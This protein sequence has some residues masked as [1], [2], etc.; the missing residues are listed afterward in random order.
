MN[1]NDSEEIM[2]IY[3]NLRE[4]YPHGHEKFIKITLNEM[5][6][7]SDKNFDYASGGHSLGNFYRVSS[8]LSLYPGLKLSQPI[9]VCIVYALKQIDAVL[10]SLSRGEEGKVEGN[11]KRLEY[12]SVYIKIAQIIND[13]K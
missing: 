7:H 8:I 1:I 4:M 10:W 5:K 3:N 6:L 13:E 9:V 2:E 11:T 12:V